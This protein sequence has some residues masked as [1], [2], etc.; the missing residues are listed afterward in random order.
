[1]RLGMDLRI[2]VATATLGLAVG[3]AMACGGPPVCTVQD[4]TNTDLNVRD[5]PNGKVLMTLRDGQEVEIVDHR[6]AGGQR[7]ARVA[8]FE[9]MEP[10][11]VFARYVTCKAGGSGD[12]VP[13][14]VT[15]PTGTPLN[16]RAEA[17]GEVIGQVR[18]GVTVRALE[19]TT[20]NGQE[21]VLVEKWGEDSAIGW[22]YDPY[23]K[24]EEDEGAH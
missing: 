21:W 11:W 12:V 5:G 6:E 20:R 8:K 14:K 18:N 15:D 22:V 17:G 19:R 9:Y 4:P 10:G 16:I 24:C 13:C 3:P 23:L 1:M 2:L 7:W